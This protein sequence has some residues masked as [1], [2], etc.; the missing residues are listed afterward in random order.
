MIKEFGVIKH[1]QEHT[2]TF[3][4]KKKKPEKPKQNQTILNHFYQVS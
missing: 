2:G 1:H 3:T 4:N